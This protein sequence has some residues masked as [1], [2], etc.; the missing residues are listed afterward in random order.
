M[1]IG[2][3]GD[4]KGGNGRNI[5]DAW[6]GRA[7]RALASSGYIGLSLCGVVVLL[8]SVLIRFWRFFLWPVSRPARPG[9]ERWRSGSCPHFDLSSFPLAAAAMAVIAAPAAARPAQVMV[10]TMLNFLLCC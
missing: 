9:R 7:A 2:G 6:G 3:I 1:S 8:G 4:G 5:R 10:M